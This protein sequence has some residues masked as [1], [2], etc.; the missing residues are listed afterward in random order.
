[1]ETAKETKDTEKRLSTMDFAT[2]ERR[3]RNIE[4][5]EEMKD[6]NVEPVKVKNDRVSAAGEGRPQSPSVETSPLMLAKAEEN[7]R[8]RWNSIQT[9]FV[10]EPRRAVEQA[11]ELVAELMQ[12]LARSFSN[13]R[14]NLEMQWQRSEQVST[15]DLHGALRRYRSFFDRLLS[16]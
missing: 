2:E 1:M 4:R 16:I 7:F 13:Q 15:E 12:H 10:D 6:R 11:D 14:S 3:G 8:S 5:A 9:S